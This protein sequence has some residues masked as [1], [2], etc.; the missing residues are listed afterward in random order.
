[1]QV[2]DSVGNEIV[3]MSNAVV[4]YLSSTARVEQEEAL[5]NQLEALG[6]PLLFAHL[7]S[8]FTCI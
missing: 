1:V 3:V 8:M 4:V 5:I 7:G 6:I 2:K